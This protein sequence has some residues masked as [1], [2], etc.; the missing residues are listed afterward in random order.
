MV[1]KHFKNSDEL[2]HTNLLNLEIPNSNISKDKINRAL[3]S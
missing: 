3:F 2:C 1:K